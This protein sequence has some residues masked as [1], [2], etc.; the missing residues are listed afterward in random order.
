ME[1]NELYHNM[2]FFWEGPACIESIFIVWT[3]FHDFCN[4]WIATSGPNPAWWR[5]IPAYKCLDLITICELLF[6]HSPFE[7]WPHVLYVIQDPESCLSTEPKC[8]CNDLQATSLSLLPCNLVLHHHH[9][10]HRSSPDCFWMVGRSCSC[11]MFWYHSL[12]GVFLGRIVREPTYL[13]TNLDHTWMLHC[14]YDTGLMSAFN[15]SF[16]GQ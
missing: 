12:F 10:M 14:W 8:Q 3:L 5:S 1:N 15:F 7:D 16:F 9:Q 11:R 6:V 4:C 2:L 13:D